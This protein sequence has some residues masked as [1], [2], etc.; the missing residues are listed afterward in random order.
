M[1]TDGQTDRQ[2]ETDVTKLTVAFRNFV[3]ALKMT[4]RGAA[5]HATHVGRQP[6]AAAATWPEPQATTHRAQA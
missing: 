6:T 2:T 3:K 5:T 1:R 4:L